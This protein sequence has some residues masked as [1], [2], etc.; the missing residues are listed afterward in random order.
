MHSADAQSN[1]F[2]ELL[3]YLHFLCL[4]LL[5]RDHEI[6]ESAGTDTAAR[7]LHMAA[8]EPYMTAGESNTAKEPGTAGEQD[9]VAEESTRVGMTADDLHILLASAH[10]VSLMIRE[11]I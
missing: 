7:E 6:F 1:V 8:R 4:L 2:F 5:M 3:F 9:M 11:R 10:L